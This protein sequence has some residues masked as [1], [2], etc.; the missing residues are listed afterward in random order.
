MFEWMFTPEGWLAFATLCFLEIVLGIDNLIFIS[1]L[2]Q[3]VHEKVRKQARL[4]G[5]SL[6]MIFRLGLLLSLS[7]LMGLT[8]PLFE[9]FSKE[10][11]WRDIILLG[12]GLFLIAKSTL[13]IHH[14]LDI[15]SGDADKKPRATL[16]FVSA[17]VQII[18]LDIVFSL[19]SVITAVGMTNDI[20]IMFAAIIVAVVVMMISSGTIYNIIQ[21]YPTLKMLALSFLVLIGVV[22][23]GEGSGL[24]IPKAYVY[25]AIAFSLSVEFLNIKLHSKLNKAKE[26]ASQST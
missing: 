13:E 4:I 5:L 6:A 8:E 3:R 1:I 15:V 17:L 20:P 12:G 25:F 18:I 7:W 26:Q 23:V 16:G 10:I 14:S 2:V 21:T 9:I 22:L 24:H 19:D 11:S